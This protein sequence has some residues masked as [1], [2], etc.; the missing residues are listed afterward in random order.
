MLIATGADLTLVPSGIKLDY[1]QPLYPKLSHSKDELQPV[2]VAG[3]FNGCVQI[4]IQE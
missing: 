3:F 2:A 4:L 1:T